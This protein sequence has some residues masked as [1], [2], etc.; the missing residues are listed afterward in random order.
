MGK[1]RKTM[2]GDNPLLSRST[3]LHNELDRYVKTLIS[4]YTP[5]KIILFGSIV[6]GNIREWS[7]IDMVIIKNTDKPFLER[8][9]D[10]TRLLKPKAG[11]DV[12]VYTP[13]EFDDLSRSRQFFKEEVIAKGKVIYER[14]C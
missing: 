5:D 4:D 14:P 13:D 12:M 10:I 6:S 1:K 2:I 9:R 11:L 3:L 8:I 7:D